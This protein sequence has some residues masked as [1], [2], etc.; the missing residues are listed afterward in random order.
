MERQETLASIILDL[1]NRRFLI[2]DGAPCVAPHEE[3]PVVPVAL[4]ASA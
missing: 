1:D 4:A 3:V 2:S